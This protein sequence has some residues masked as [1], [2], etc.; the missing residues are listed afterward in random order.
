MNPLWRSPPSIRGRLVRALAGWSLLWCC[1]LGL[2][3]W[4]AVREE[5][6]ELLD[7]SLQAAAEGL[8]GP[9]AQLLGNGVQ[10]E[11]LPPAPGSSGRFVW[12]LVSHQGT[13]RLL[14]GSRGAPAEPLQ[15]TPTPGFSTRPRWRVYGMAAGHDG[16][17]LYVAQTRDERVEAE[18]EIGF[19]VL[20]S[21][22]PM[23]LL[24][25]LWLRAR[26]RHELQPLQDLSQRL[27][28]H[29]PLQPGAT[30]GPARHEELRPVH[31]AI[32]ALA[33][34]LAQRVARERAFTAHAAHAL[35]TPLAGIDAQLAV[36][37]REAA[38]AQQGRLQRVRAAAVR[39]QHVVVAL[40]T[41]F[42]SGAEVQ[43]ETLDL[44]ALVA[45][46]PLEGLTLE[47]QATHRLRA[48]VD[49]V[50]AALLNLLDNSLRHGGHHVLISTPAPGRLQ[51]QDDGPGVSSERLQA[52]QQAL[53]DENYQGR[54]GLG[55]MLADMVARAHGGHLR[56]PPVPQGFAACMELGHD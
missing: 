2:A 13:A 16:Q 15:L 1:A 32:D 40:L 21:G 14:S 7:D 38:P 42:R 5:V 18:A 51:V 33:A 3:V 52:L 54:T 9:F 47:V 36:A 41:L 48:D 20:M 35:R 34:R 25:L 53:D 45:R 8:I 4:L 23:A 11:P 24:A 44:A 39:L 28:Q 50:T 43:R 46:M 10:P 55:L 49:L 30:L 17:M 19:A 12:Q 29:D 26:L 22:L 27:A 6:D 31:G 37:L 56:L